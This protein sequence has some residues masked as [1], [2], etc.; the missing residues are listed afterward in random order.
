MKKIVFAVCILLVISLFCACGPQFTVQ[1][2]QTELGVISAKVTK[3]FA[4]VTP[5]EADHQLLVVTMQAQT[6]EP[7]LSALTDAIFG[8]TPSTAAD[9]TGAYPCTSIAFSQDS[10]S[11]SVYAIFEVPASLKNKTVTISGED[12]D[13]FSLQEK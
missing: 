7:D 3:D 2:A 1:I 5:A 4:D 12:F 10:D 13:S 11:T 9:E 6:L 8:D